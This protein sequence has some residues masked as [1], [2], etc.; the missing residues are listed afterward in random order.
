[1]YRCADT[2]KIS[3]GNKVTSI[4]FALL[5]CEYGQWTYLGEL[6]GSQV[7]RVAILVK[8]I[9]IYQSGVNAYISSAQLLTNQYLPNA[10]KAFLMLLTRLSTENVNEILLRPI[11]KF[12]MSKKR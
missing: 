7:S 1:M 10:Y 3:V 5:S 4:G 8:K 6:G 11:I 2:Q 12:D 9:A